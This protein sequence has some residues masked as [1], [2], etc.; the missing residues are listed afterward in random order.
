[1]ANINIPQK[2]PG[3]K[4]SAK[5]VNEM[6]SAISLS[7]TQQRM[8][9]EEYFKLETIDENCIYVLTDANGF[10]DYL[11]LGSLLIAKRD[12]GNGS[13]GYPYEFPIIF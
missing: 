7:L 5:E 1:M 8:L 3:D 2:K 12:K 10:V 4:F 6:T 11:Y 9:T 13:V